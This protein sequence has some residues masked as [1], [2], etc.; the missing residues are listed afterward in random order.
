MFSCAMILPISEP[1]MSWVESCES[2]WAQACSSRWA[3]AYTRARSG[4]CFQ[5]NQFRWRLS[6]A[7]AIR[8]CAGWVIPRNRAKQHWT[9]LRD[10]LCKCRRVI[11]PSGLSGSAQKRFLSRVKAEVLERLRKQGYDIP[12]EAIKAG[13]QNRYIAILLS[14]ESLY[15]PDQALRPELLIEI[16]ARPPILAPV[17]CGYDTIVNEMLGRA[18]RTGTIACLNIRETIAGKNA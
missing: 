7:S 12:P 17:I 1:T 6:L 9:T 11:L 4:R 8:H 14:Y 15:P 10:A 16:S 5:A 18:E 2:S 3:T 13:N